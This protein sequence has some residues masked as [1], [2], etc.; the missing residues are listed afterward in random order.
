MF[1]LTLC[2]SQRYFLSLSMSSEFHFIFTNSIPFLPSFLPPLLASDP[3]QYCKGKDPRRAD[4][5]KDE[6]T[7]ASV[8][9][10]FQ[11]SPRVSRTWSDLAHLGR[12][13][14]TDPIVLKGIQSVTDAAHAIQ[15]GMDGIWVSNHGGH[16]VDGAVP[17]LIQLPAIAEY[18]NSLPRKEGEEKKTIIFDSGVRCGADI[19]KA[20]CLG[21]D[22]VAVGRPWCWGLAVNG[23]DGVRNVL[24]TLLADF[25][26]NA[27]LAGFQTSKELG[28]HALIKAESHI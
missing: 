17:C 21:A 15:A 19:I 9:A 1:S 11:L 24:K 6:I 20:L 13:W 28:R 23:E 22:R 4:V 12:L 16:Q 7:S 25:E 8:A 26:L 14:G 2:S 5:T 10:I 27:G 3:S 18:I